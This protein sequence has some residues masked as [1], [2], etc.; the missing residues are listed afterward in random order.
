[1][2][3]V[4]DVVKNAE[5]S[6]SHTEMAWSQLMEVGGGWVIELDIQDFFGSLDRGQLREVLRKRIPGAG[7]PHARI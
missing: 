5:G 6:I 4:A 7:V 1:M 3:A 2:I